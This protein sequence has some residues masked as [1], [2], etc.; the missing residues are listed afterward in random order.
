MSNV[1]AADFVNGLLTA[2]TRGIVGGKLA[3]GV[4]LF[5]VCDKHGPAMRR[6]AT[7]MRQARDSKKP[8]KV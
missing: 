7:G 3:K 2:W 5:A 6:R 1:W 8:R 4:K